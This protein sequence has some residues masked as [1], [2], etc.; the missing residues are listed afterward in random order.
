MGSECGHQLTFKRQTY[1]VERFSLSGYWF[2]AHRGFPKHSDSKGWVSW[3]LTVSL[4][5][6]ISEIMILP[7]IRSNHASRWHAIYIHLPTA[8]SFNSN[9]MEYLGIAH[10]HQPS[11]CRKSWGQF[12]VGG[13]FRPSSETLRSAEAWQA[14]VRLITPMTWP[15]PQ[16]VW[17][18][19][20]HL[21]HLQRSTFF[22]LEIV[23]RCV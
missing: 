10:W 6:P 5:L 16:N 20:T 11:G 18:H 8:W 7:M 4:T 17:A 19:P 22:L 14:A 9:S 21:T 2:A 1:G 23:L 15:I 12:A 13:R 3:F